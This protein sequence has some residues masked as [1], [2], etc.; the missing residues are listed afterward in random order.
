M[1]S[2]LTKAQILEADDLPTEIVEVP[3]WN[4]SVIV[5]TITGS[6]RDAFEASVI[7]ES[8]GKNMEYLRSKLVAL[9]VVDE[10]GNHL[11]TMNDAK[12]LGEKSA[13]AIDKVFSVAQRL[14]GLSKKDVEELT[15]NLSEGQ[16]ADSTSA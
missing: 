3:E 13:R 4:G 7:T 11:F 9:S 6:E 2:T 16:S 8:G 1:L 15:E 5:R 12:E 10:E 14:S